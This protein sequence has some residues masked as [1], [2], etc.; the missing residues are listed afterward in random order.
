MYLNVILRIFMS[1]KVV[2]IIWV[3]LRFECRYLLT[4]Y[5]Y[6]DVEKVQVT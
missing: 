1:I 6:N 2:F 3:I 4:V 5:Y